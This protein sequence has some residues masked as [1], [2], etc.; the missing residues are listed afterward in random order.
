MKR[1][2]VKAYLRDGSFSFDRRVALEWNV[3]R[4]EF[5]L[6]LG[7]TRSFFLRF[8]C[9]NHDLLNFR[10]YIVLWFQ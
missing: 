3:L 6:H 5:L 2:F 4:P 1:D 7:I 10:I 9:C 8:L